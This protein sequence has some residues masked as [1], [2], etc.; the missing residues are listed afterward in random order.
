MW[1]NIHTEWHRN[2]IWISRIHWAQN[3]VVLMYMKM[4]TLCEDSGYSNWQMNILNNILLVSLYHLGSVWWGKNLIYKLTR[5]PTAGASLINISGLIFH[6]KSIWHNREKQGIHFVYILPLSQWQKNT[7][8][9]IPL[10]RLHSQIEKELLAEIN[11]I[12]RQGNGN[13][14][15]NIQRKHYRLSIYGSQSACMS[16]KQHRC[17]YM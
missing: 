5:T 8:Q 16:A 4:F 15:H 3:T 14:E 9:L 7:F 13:E 6:A 11:W 12:L 10:S 2:R 1:H 17:V